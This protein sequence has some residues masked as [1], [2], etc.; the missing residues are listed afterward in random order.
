[1][2]ILRSDILNDIRNNISAFTYNSRYKSYIH[3][4][5]NLIF[6]WHGASFVLDVQ[7]AR[8]YIINR[9]TGDVVAFVVSDT[10]YSHASLNDGN[11]F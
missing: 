5:I 1:M 7:L 11:T 4:T 3:F 2:H 9:S 10:M 6:Q 8:V